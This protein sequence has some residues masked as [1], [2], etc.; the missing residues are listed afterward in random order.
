MKRVV[1]I[2]DLHSGHRGG[3]TPPDWQ[4]NLDS[5]NPDRAKWA[6]LQH[7]TWQWYADKLASLQPI[8]TL[9]VNGDA[10]DG[11]GQASGGSENITSDRNEQCEMAAVAICQAEANRVMMIRGTPYH[12]GKEE[13]FEDL[14][15]FNVGA[16][17]IE[18]HGYY[19]IY[20]NV[21]DCKHKVGSSAIPHGRWTATARS[22]LWNTLWAERGLVPHAN[23][24]VR[25]HVHYHIEGSDSQRRFFTTPAL[26]SWTQY[27]GQQCE[28]TIDYGLIELQFEED[29]NYTFTPH[30]LDLKFSKQEAVKL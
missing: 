1:I 14:I 6:K 19:E 24:I 28:S 15:A 17:S 10:I 8:D 3:L 4:Y 16:D 27:G 20:G 29:G 11:K 2:S 26:Q 25:S 23:I 5:D 18:N 21:I 30:F 7:T 12:G 9:I 13:N 22:A